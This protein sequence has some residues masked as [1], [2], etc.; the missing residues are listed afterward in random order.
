[1][2]N[3]RFYDPQP[4]QDGQAL[5]LSSDAA[6]HAVNVLRLKVGQTITLFD[7]EG[8]EA[9]AIIDV[10]QRQRVGVLIQ[11]STLLS[12]ESP[13][14]LHLA[15]GLSKNDKMELIIQKAVEL[16]VTDFTPLIT[17]YTPI[18]L[19][20]KRLEKKAHQWKKMIQSA[21]EQCGRNTLMTLHPICPFDE[22]LK[23]VKETLTL[24]LDP[25]SKTTLKTLSH[26]PKSL[27]VLIGPEGGFCD[28]EQQK[29][30]DSGCTGISL[31]KRILRTETA[32]LAVCTLIQAEWG[33]LLSLG[34]S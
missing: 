8:R 20:P 29:A 15:Q 32:T 3:Y 6:H 28:A 4:Y 16:G 14:R 10:I 26:R 17:Q 7:G 1:M 5:Q 11:S 2:P 27:S 30:L 13:L 19:D 18:K 33:D 34:S 25:R 12:R 22:Y 23:R 31:G 9:T 21:S 24:F